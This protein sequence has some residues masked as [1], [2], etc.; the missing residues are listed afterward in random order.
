MK[1][2]IAGSRA[3]TTRQHIDMAISL[4]NFKITEVICG[5]ARGADLLGKDWADEN[6]I[7]IIKKPADWDTFSISKKHNYIGRE[8]MLS[9]YMLLFFFIFL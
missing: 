1:V 3:G 7:P 8:H 9:T 4:S 2:I 6:N 5:M